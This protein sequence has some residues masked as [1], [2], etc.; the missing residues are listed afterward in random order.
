[1]D[2]LHIPAGLSREMP[3]E[4][5]VARARADFPI[6]SRTV[7]GRPLVYLDN[8]ATTQKPRQV[9]DA[10]VRYYETTNANIHRG[11]HTLAE[12][13]TALYEGARESRVDALGSRVQVWIL[14]ANE[15]GSADWQSA[16]WTGAFMLQDFQPGVSARMTRNPNYIHEGRPYFDEVE[17]IG[18]TDVEFIYAEGLA[19]GAD[20]ASKAFAEAAA[21]I[22]EVVV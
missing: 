3:R 21:R 11:I 22:E 19:M 8:A 13:A 10:L 7:N 15:D 6:L 5:D 20:S 16:N 12:E 1:M 18:I 9:I 14:P 17:F 4:M 2:G